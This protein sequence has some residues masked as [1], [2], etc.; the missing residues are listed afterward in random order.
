MTGYL[1]NFIPNYA[2]ITAPLRKLKGKKEKFQWGKDSSFQ[3]L[4]DAVAKATTMS[5]SQKTDNTQNRSKFQ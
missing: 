4:K 5:Y 3:I 1:D 2:I